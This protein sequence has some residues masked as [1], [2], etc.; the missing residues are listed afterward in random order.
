MTTRGFSTT[1]IHEGEGKTDP[2][3]PL[4]TPIYETTTF[5]FDN[6]EQIREYNEGSRSKFLY[7]R[8]EN[9]LLYTSPS[10]RD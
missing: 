6:A 1:L 10:P 8:Y 5:I 2:P 7:S 9:C 4:T 3:A